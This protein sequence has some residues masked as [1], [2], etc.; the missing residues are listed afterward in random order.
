MRPI[1]VAIFWFV[2]GTLFANPFNLD[3]EGDY[4]SPFVDVMRANHDGAFYDQQAADWEAIAKGECSEED[5][6]FHY[7]KTA[8]A[9]LPYRLGN[10]R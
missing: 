1:L 8:T 3:T 10:N 4:P 2:F 6:W 7:Y 5:A 9:S